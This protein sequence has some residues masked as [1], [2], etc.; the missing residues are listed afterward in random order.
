M[1]AAV[2]RHRAALA[3]LGVLALVA[4][5]CSEAC[6]VI[7]RGCE[8]RVEAWTILDHFFVVG[9]VKD[10]GYFKLQLEMNSCAEVRSACFRDRGGPHWTDSDKLLDAIARMAELADA[11]GGGKTKTDFKALA[12]DARRVLARA[13]GVTR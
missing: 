2:R 12:R 1:G 9:Q 4:A 11:H 3:L 8:A 6:R 13:Q 7:D 10:P 5:G